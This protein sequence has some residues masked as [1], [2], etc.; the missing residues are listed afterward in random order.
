MGQV[1]GIGTCSGATRDHLARLDVE[2]C[3]DSAARWIQ[4][5]V[6]NATWNAYSKVWQ[7]WLTFV[8]GLEVSP[9]GQDVGIAVLYFFTLKMEQG[10]L[11]I[12]GRTDPS[13]PGFPVQ[14][15]GVQGFHQGVL[16]EQAEVTEVRM[17]VSRSCLECCRVPCAA[18]LTSVHYSGGHLRL[19]FS[20]R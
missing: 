19:P 17:G 16:G 20:G 4:R 15:A 14:V 13:R 9:V 11:R 10:G 5:S 3:F 18:R 2:H 6:S 7:E 12:R 8:Q 1:P